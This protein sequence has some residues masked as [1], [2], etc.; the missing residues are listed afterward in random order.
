MS[1]AAIA[2]TPGARVGSYARRLVGDRLRLGEVPR[3]H[4]VP[5]PVQ[6]APRAPFVVLVLG[7]LGV[8][9]LGLLLLHT[10]MEQRS[11]ALHDLERSNELLAE[12]VQE[13]RD[14][15]DAREAPAGLAAE[16]QALG[17]VPTASSAFLD[18]GDATIKGRLAPSQARAL[19]APSVEPEHE[20]GTGPIQPVQPA[21]TPK[22][23]EDE[24]A[25]QPAG[26]GSATPSPTPTGTA[27]P[28]PADSAR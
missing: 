21:P 3:L 4:L 8:G 24:A 25:K 14:D 17:M 20:L 19:A 27:T 9:L 5:R 6:N 18:L 7:L 16:A 22:P 13:L 23:A 2:G 11:F 26:D 28:S 1:E 15:V 10:V 12:R